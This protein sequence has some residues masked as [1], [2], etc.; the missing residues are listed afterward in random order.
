METQTKTNMFTGMAVRIAGNSVIPVDALDAILDAS[1]TT[2]EGLINNA[3]V[4]MEQEQREAETFAQDA[5]EQTEEAA[6][7]YAAA[8]REAKQ[9]L[10][11]AQE[12]I[13]R[14]K[15][16]AAIHAASADKIRKALEFTNGRA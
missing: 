4:R 11:E 9:K 6:S 16:E 7:E 8:I 14:I 13:D 12:E 2:M 10:A 15:S 1:G 3:R 5:A